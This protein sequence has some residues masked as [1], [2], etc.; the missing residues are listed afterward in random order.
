MTPAVSLFIPGKPIAFARAGSKG[1]RRFTPGPQASYKLAVGHIA[2]AA[3]SKAGYK[4]FEG[5]LEL[6]YRATFDW[7]ETWSQRRKDKIRWKSSKPDVDNA[8]KLAADALNQIVY[9]DDAQIA[10]LRAQKVYGLPEG[11]TITIAPLVDEAELSD[12]VPA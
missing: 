4:P 3:M 10:S 8:A 7:P 1:A 12:Q 11:V 9:L 2:R 6:T 5:P